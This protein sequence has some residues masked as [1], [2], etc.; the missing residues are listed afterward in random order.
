MTNVYCDF[1]TYHN[2]LGSLPYDHNTSS[3]IHTTNKEAK[4]NQTTK[5]KKTEKMYAI[6][7]DGI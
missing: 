7:I 4:S 3:Y 6:R 1:K 2:G 5:N